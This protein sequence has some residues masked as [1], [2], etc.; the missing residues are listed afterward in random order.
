MPRLAV[1]LL[2]SCLVPLLGCGSSDGG[3]GEF[4]VVGSSPPGSPWSQQWQRFEAALA[5]DPEAGLRPELFVQAQLGDPERSLQAL[6]RG[7]VQLGGFPLSAAA[8]LVPEVALLQ[9]PYLFRSES[10][11][12]HVVDGFLQAPLNQLFEAQGVT[13]LRWTEAGWNHLFATSAVVAPSDLAGMPVRAQPTPASRRL[14]AELGAD[15]RPLPYSELLSGLQTGLVRGGDGHLVMILAG[16]ISKEARHLSLTAHA[17]EVGVIL[18]NTNWWRSLSGRQRDALLAALGPRHQLREEVAAFS[19][20]LLAEAEQQGRVQVHRPAPAEL[21]AWR[22]AT[23]GVRSR[24]VQEIGGDA[25]HIDGLIEAGRR[26]FATRNPE[27]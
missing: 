20:R 15:V 13:V 24:L 26:D 5:A 25:L 23:A 3:S 12:D 18:A 17:F 4:R 9:L 2:L 14:F 21:E 11:V 8:S 19:A 7:R 1:A 10:E 27:G 6:R 16:G 22:S